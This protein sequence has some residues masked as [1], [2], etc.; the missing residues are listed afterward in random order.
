[1]SENLSS[2]EYTLPFIVQGER[3]HCAGPRQVGPASRSLFY[4]RCGGLHLQLLSVVF[5]TG[6]LM[7][8]S[9]TW[10]QSY[11]ALQAQ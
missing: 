10:I 1:V 7:C 8:V 5:S 9:A 3:L 11:A 2:N 4:E 6:K